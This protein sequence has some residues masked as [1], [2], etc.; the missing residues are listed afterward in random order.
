MSSGY[1]KFWEARYEFKYREFAEKLEFFLDKAVEQKPHKGVRSTIW[2]ILGVA[3]MHRGLL[4]DW[5]E[6]LRY[7]YNVLVKHNYAV[8]SLF[9]V[10]DD[11]TEVKSE[12]IFTFPEPEC[13]RRLKCSEFTGCLILEEA[14]IGKWARSQCL[15]RTCRY[16]S[17]RDGGASWSGT[18]TN[19]EIIDEHVNGELV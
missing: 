10:L 11:G 14:F 5:C 13:Y 8:I 16:P 4:R 2:G 7:D 6:R 3:E 15:E 12:F 9:K 18:M 17:I 19:N 1:Y